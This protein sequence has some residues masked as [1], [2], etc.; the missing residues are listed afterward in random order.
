MFTICC[1]GGAFRS[2]LFL[3]LPTQYLR[4]VLLGGLLLFSY[5][6]NAQNWR[7]TQNGDGHTLIEFLGKT[8][9]FEF[10]MSGREVLTGF[11]VGHDLPKARNHLFYN[12]RLDGYGGLPLGSC[13]RRGY[14]LP[15][16]DP[17]AE[18]CTANENKDLMRVWDN[19]NPN[20]KNVVLKN[21]TIERAF[22]TYNLVDGEVVKASR[23]LPH[24]DTFQ[25]FYTGRS[26]E[27]P[28]W[29]VIQ[30]SIIK[31]SDNSLMISGGSRFDGVVYQNLHTSCESGFTM[32]SRARIINDYAHFQPDNDDFSRFSCGNQ[33]T[34]GSDQP[35]I[36]WLV[37]VQ[38]SSGASI[39]INNK[40]A[41]VIAVGSDAESYRIKTRNAQRRLVD[42]S[43]VRRYASL[44]AA[45]QSE[46]RPPMIELSCAGWANPPT[47]CESRRGYL[48]N[49]AALPLPVMA[50][51]IM[52][53]ED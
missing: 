9:I 34:F 47:N 15:S 22:R 35:A 11:P 18:L 7:P 44:E 30:D 41:A 13:L 27:D 48:G 10:E 49:S 37:D 17:N 3:K 31:N 19:R 50:P 23:E 12:L 20:L 39:R 1:H 8:E 43:N 2:L 52:L 16:S 26:Q 6:A 38:T 51:I 33:M 4:L 24:V 36:V 42:H 45:L 29:L 53:L 32:D 40:N 46:T 21:M 28:D 25:T 5:S 14:L